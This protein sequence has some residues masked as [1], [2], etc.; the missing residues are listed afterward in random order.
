MIEIQRVLKQAGRRLFLIDLMRTLA[1]TSS[2]AIFALIVARVTDFFWPWVGS[3]AFGWMGLVAGLVGACVI[4]AI[5]WSVVRRARSAEVAREVDERAN[6]RESI[7][8]ALCVEKSEDPWA[9][10]VVE[11]ARDRAAGVNVKQTVPYVSPRLAPMPMAFLLV[12]TVV[13]FSMGGHYIWPEAA[14]RAE[15]QAKL[16]DVAAALAKDEE[17]ITELLEKAKLDLDGLGDDL[18]LDGDLPEN[19]TPDQLQREML[20]KMTTM[21]DRIKEQLE[22]GDQ[23]RKLEAMKKMMRNLRKPGPGPL[24]EMASAMQRGDFAKAKQELDKLAEKL[25]NKELDAGEREQ[26]AKQMENM[27]N[28][29]KELADLQKQLKEE[30]QKAGLSE[31][32]AAKLAQNPAGLKEALKNMDGLSDAQKEQLQSASESMKAASQNASKMSSALSQMAQGMTSSGMTQ[33]GMEGMGQMGEQLSSAEMMSAEM[34]S[35]KT[36]LGQCQSMMESL[37]Q[38]N[39]NGE[40]YSQNSSMKPWSAGDSTRQGNS[41]GG[42]GRGTGWSPEAQESDFDKKREKDSPKKHEGPIIG[43]TLVQGSTI[44]GESRAKFA[45]AVTIAE[46]VAQEEIANSEVPPEHQEAVK[47]YFGRLKEQADA[48]KSKDAGEK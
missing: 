41:S 45:E 43:E 18:D 19:M 44:R 30:L 12:L 7:S 37:G 5:G 25:G 40:G 33:E 15:Q 35:L 6:L 47:K 34:Q 14:K 22:Q 3:I 26:M 1:V 11:T 13:W 32:Q 2:L 48:K 8:T 23:N 4:G 17:K 16:T 28:Q 9:R 38:C 42:P 10:A 46:K 39:A 29:L 27:A 20:K 24:D 36:A 31:E 21:A